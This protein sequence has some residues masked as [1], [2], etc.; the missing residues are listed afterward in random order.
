M[1]NC[2]CAASS[3]QCTEYTYVFSFFFL[4]FCIFLWHIEIWCIDFSKNFA[5]NENDGNYSNKIKCT[6]ELKFL[7]EGVFFLFISSAQTLIE[8]G[9]CNQCS[10]CKQTCCNPVLINTSVLQLWYVYRSNMIH[11]H[12]N[13]IISVINMWGTAMYRL[14]HK[15]TSCST[16]G[17]S[18]I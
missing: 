13:S 14:Q 9:D 4:V 7:V 12:F 10:L 15:K 18:H 17:Y 3:L 8:N 11:F 2:Y 1:E 5:F 16:H 6:R